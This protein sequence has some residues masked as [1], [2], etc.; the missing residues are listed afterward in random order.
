MDFVDSLRLHARWLSRGLVDASRWDVVLTD[1]SSCVCLSPPSR[2]FSHVNQ[3]SMNINPPATHSS[4]HTSSN[5]SR[6]I[7]SRSPPS[8]S[9][10]PSSTR[11]R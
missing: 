4:V 6:Q 2:S 10:P 8:S 3:L 9:R 7:S 11:S 5:P 1:L